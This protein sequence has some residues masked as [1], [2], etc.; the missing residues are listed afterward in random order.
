MTVWEYPDSA[1]FFYPIKRHA[2]TVFKQG[3]HCFGGVIILFFTHFIRCFGGEDR[4]AQVAA[5]FFQ[6]AVFP[7]HRWLRD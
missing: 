5:Q 6:F 4:P 2:G 7:V 3:H 1:G